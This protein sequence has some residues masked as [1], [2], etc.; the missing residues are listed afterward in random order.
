MKVVIKGKGEV[1]KNTKYIKGIHL[2]SK[3]VSPQS[4]SPPVEA[5]ARTLVQ[6]IFLQRDIKLYFPRS[7]ECVCHCMVQHAHT[8]KQ[9]RKVD[10]LSSTL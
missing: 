5:A 1:K 6:V 3:F 4:L 2:R 9:D 7:S 8:H 10:T